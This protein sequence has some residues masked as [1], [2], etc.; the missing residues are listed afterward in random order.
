MLLERIETNNHSI[1]DVAEEEM[2]APLYYKK[3]LSRIV[4]FCALRSLVE[5][6]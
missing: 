6:K 4:I 1:D 5:A 3:R 2:N